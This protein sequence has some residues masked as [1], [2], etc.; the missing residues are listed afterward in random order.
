MLVFATSSA[1]IAA[2]EAARKAGEALRVSQSALDVE[3]EQVLGQSRCDNDKHTI[4]RVN[5]YIMDEQDIRFVIPAGKG[6]NDFFPVDI[7]FENL[8]RCALT[9]VRVFLCLFRPTDDPKNDKPF[10]HELR[11][12]NIAAEKDI[13]VKLFMRKDVLAHPKIAWAPVAIVAGAELE[14]DP[15]DTLVITK[16]QASGGAIDFDV[17]FAYELETGPAE[18]PEKKA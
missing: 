11:L 15:M 12:D 1:F 16:K 10:S 13:H 3:T 8:G 5:L 18:E 4:P 17:A 2:Y 9:Q 7:D 6:V 14:Y